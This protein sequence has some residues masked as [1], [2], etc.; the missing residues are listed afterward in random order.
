MLTC[1]LIYS[2][3]LVIGVLSGR[4]KWN[5]VITNFI[6]FQITRKKTST[7]FR[8]PPKNV[9]WTFLVAT[10]VW[11][12]SLTKVQVGFRLFIFLVCSVEVME[13]KNP[14]ENWVGFHGKLLENTKET[15][16]FN[17]KNFDQPL[18]LNG[19]L[20]FWFISVYFFEKPFKTKT[21]NMNFMNSMR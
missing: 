8:H 15:L 17:E 14:I 7:L 4:V 16:V 5:Q 13:K 12:W 6:L 1:E 11:L 21:F 2:C 18:A 19:F 10:T 20:F 9:H 3:L